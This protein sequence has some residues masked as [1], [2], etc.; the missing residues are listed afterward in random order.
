MSLDT[1]RAPADEQVTIG[2]FRTDGSNRHRK[3]V[4]VPY[5]PIPAG[6]RPMPVPSPGSLV[7]KYG[8]K[9]RSTTHGSITVGLSSFLLKPD[10]F[11]TISEELRE[12]GHPV[13]HGCV[14]REKRARDHNRPVLYRLKNKN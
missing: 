6:E 11:L 1:V 3:G 5:D 7:V 4:I 14:G 12:G 13:L 2:R 9:M 10:R 8:W